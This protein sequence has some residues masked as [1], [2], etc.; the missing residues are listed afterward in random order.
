M[1]GGHWD[2]L[3]YRLTDVVEDIDRLVEKNGQPK[4]EEEL[5]DERWHDDEWY[6]KYPEE[7][8]HHKY[9]DDVIRNFKVAAAIV[10]TAQIYMQ[11]MDWL[12]SGDDGSE[13]FVRRLDE[14]LSELA[15]KLKKKSDDQVDN[16]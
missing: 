12:L 1:S 15:T 10:A 16:K 14:D 13:S 9:S 7:K 6:E 2:Y 5:K 11:R 3:Q 8:F 4:T